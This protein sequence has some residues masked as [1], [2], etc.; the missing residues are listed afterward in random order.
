MNVDKIIKERRSIRYFKKKDV[1]WG[2]IHEILESCIY[3][4]CAGGIQNWRLVVMKNK[5][6]LNQIC[7]NQEAVVKAD[8]LVVVCSDNEDLKRHY[9]DRWDIF[10]IQNTSA[11]IQNMMLK[12]HSMKIGSCWIGVYREPEMKNLLKIPDGVDIHAVLAFGYANEK[13]EIPL[14]ASLNNIIGYDQYGNNRKDSLPLI[15]K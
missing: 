15:K 9:K 12:A 3:A 1:S 11:A 13:P 2:K 4:P 14:R 10:S 6:Q 7:F 5:G 8:F